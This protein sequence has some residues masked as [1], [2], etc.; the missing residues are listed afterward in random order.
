MLNEK[1]KNEIREYALS[2]VDEEICGLLISKNSKISFYKCKNISY[3]K[4]DYSILNPLDYVNASNQGEIIAHVHSQE[5]RNPSFTD[6]L[7]AAGH[8]I[9]SIIYSTKY[10]KFSVINPALKNYLN[11]DY[12][13]NSSDCFELVRNYYK[14]ELNI[15]ISNY[16]RYDKW[17]FDK[18]NLIL[19]N[20]EKEGFYKVGLKDIQI[21]DVMIFRIGGFLSHLAVYMDDNLI[22]HHPENDKSVI[23]ELSLALSKRIE[24]VIRHK[25]I[26]DE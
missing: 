5:G 23:C 3:H 26:K 9:Y 15:K 21:N 4:K 7:N 20:F 24:L 6:Y 25:D 18:P 22:L 11:L 17:E 12:K 14:N 16:N 10:D 13:I 1:L 19:D 2:K 8:K